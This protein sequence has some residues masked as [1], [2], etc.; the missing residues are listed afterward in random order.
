M[1]AHKR[2][3]TI[4]ATDMSSHEGNQEPNH[5]AMKKIL[6]LDDGKQYNVCEHRFAV[7]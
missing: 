7:H 3:T 5:N 2:Q 6:L 1:V 4:V